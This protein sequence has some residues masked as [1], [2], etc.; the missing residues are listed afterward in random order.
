MG[1][2]KSK[3]EGENH[4]PHPAGPT[5]FDVAHHIVG[6]L[7]CEFTLLGYVELLIHQHAQFFLFRAALDSF[8][9]RPVL[10]VGIALTQVQDLA[11]VVVKLMEFVSAHLSSQVPLDGIHSLQHANHTTQ[12]GVNSKLG[13]R[14]PI[15]LSTSLL[16]S[17]GP[18]TDL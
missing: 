5:A 10:V 9:V 15:P 17:T 2:H 18:S 8:F 7:C 11:F 14:A 4:L 13:E 1:C 6:F 12:L 16:S 3:A